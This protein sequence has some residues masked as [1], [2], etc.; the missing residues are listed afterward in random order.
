[1]GTHPIFESDFDCLT[2]MNLDINGLTYN[3]AEVK[4]PSSIGN[5]LL[6]SAK[7]DIFIVSLQEVDLALQLGRLLFWDQWT[8]QITKDLSEHNY[9]RV[10]SIRM[11][12]M[13]LSVF[14]KR[15]LLNQ[16]RHVKSD[17]IGTGYANFWGNKGAVSI[18]LEINGRSL[19]IINTHLP[20]GTEKEQYQ[21]RLD[22][23]P[24]IFSS[25]NFGNYSSLLD[26]DAVVWM[27]DM[28]FRI[29][30]FTREEVISKVQESTV[31]E[32][33][34]KDELTTLSYSHSILKQFNELPIRFNPTYKYN[35][36]STN[37]DSSAKKRKPAW[38]DRILFFNREINNLKQLS[39]EVDENLLIS[40]HRPVFGD[41]NFNTSTKKV[42]NCQITSSLNSTGQLIVKVTI[43]SV[44]LN[45]ENDWIAIYGPKFHDYREWK[46][47][48]YVA[49]AN[50]IQQNE[51]SH[52][53]SIEIN[54]EGL[55]GTY[56]IGYFSSI[57][58]NLISVSS[59]IKLSSR[60]VGF[61]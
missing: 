30:D 11:Q 1:M 22:S 49:F 5:I 39:Y 21:A 44:E 9:Y 51:N 2:E 42:T 47:F 50:D 12:G 46:V 54:D 33:L 56:L 26:H 4:A 52:V 38:T 53:L 25:L 48:Q 40:D 15:K 36:N 35:I 24:K 10:E 6:R 55:E 37:Y 59:E 34:A 14:A 29:R 58:Q 31:L 60:P 28:N 19:A 41:F 45:M 8:A 61:S 23:I 27:G 20:H 43:D 17:W 18:R 32:C 7:P 3:V 13:V 16:I 57:H